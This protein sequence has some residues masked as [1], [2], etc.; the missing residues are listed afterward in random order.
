MYICVH[1]HI[2]I[3]ICIYNL[4]SYSSFGRKYSLF[5]QGRC[6]A[7]RPGH[8]SGK[9]E[10]APCKARPCVRGSECPQP[11]PHPA[12]ALA[13]AAASGIE[14]P[15]GWGLAGPSPDTSL[16]WV[17]GGCFPDRDA[18]LPLPAALATLPSI[19]HPCLTCPVL[20]VSCTCMPTSGSRLYVPGMTL[21]VYYFFQTISVRSLGF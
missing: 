12:A 13:R 1:T 19:P 2:H 9:Q 21:S 10:L 16:F 5:L 15:P 8:F 11:S 7:Q 17:A 3:H 20:R 6:S 18:P 4:S 14:A